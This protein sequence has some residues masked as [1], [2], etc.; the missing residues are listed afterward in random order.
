MADDNDSPNHLKESSQIA[1]AVVVGAIVSTY[2]FIM[3]FSQWTKNRHIVIQAGITAIISLILASIADKIGSLLFT[4]FWQQAVPM[5]GVKLRLIPIPL[6][7]VIY[8]LFFALIIMGLS[9]DS[10]IRELQSELDEIKSEQ[11]DDSETR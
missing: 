2:H 10:S 4:T 3:G 8:S 1:R 6:S 5:S 7:L 9:F 11:K